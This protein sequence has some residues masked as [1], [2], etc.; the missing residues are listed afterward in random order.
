MLFLNAIVRPAACR[1]MHSPNLK[2]A[3]ILPTLV[4]HPVARSSILWKD[5]HLCAKFYCFLSIQIYQIAIFISFVLSSKNWRFLK[6]YPSRIA[7]NWIILLERLLLRPYWRTPHPF[8]VFGSDGIIQLNS[9]A[10]NND[11]L[12]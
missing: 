6:D 3:L 7:S 1:K 4:E 2:I 8:C 9:H 10:K 12:T 5:L 11:F